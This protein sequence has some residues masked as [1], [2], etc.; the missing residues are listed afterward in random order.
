VQHIPLLDDSMMSQH[1]KEESRAERQDAAKTK[2]EGSWMPNEHRQPP[3][4]RSPRVQTLRRG[5]EG[6]GVAEKKNTET[7]LKKLVP[8]SHMRSC[9]PAQASGCTGTTTTVLRGTTGGA[10]TSPWYYCII[11]RSIQQ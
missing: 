2:V 5:R 11:I 9:S 6:S 4:C 8:H 7:W 1:R 3:R 10:S